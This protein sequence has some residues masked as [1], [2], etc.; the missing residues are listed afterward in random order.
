MLTTAC[1]YLLIAFF[2]LGIESRLRQGREAKTWRVGPYD[3]GSQAVI[4]F[5]L[6]IASVIL[7]AAPVFN[8]FRSGRSRPGLP[9]GVSGLAVM[10]CGLALRYRAAKTLGA[11]YTRTLRVKTRHRVVDRGPYRILRHPGYLGVI[12]LFVG[13]GA[14]VDNWTAVAAMPVL[15][16]PAYAYRIRVEEKMLQATL[17]KAYADY[18]RR[19]W[20]LIPYI[21]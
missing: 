5:T 19:T 2:F 14:A 16:F 13:A 8:H 6:G 11:F 9:V 12:L 3:R 17:G 15:L 10:A 4:G 1:A 18:M 7:L 20:R 21:Y